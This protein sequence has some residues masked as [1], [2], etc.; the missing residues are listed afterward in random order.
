MRQDKD[1]S[2]KW[3]I[4]RY[5]DS[6]LHLVGITGFARW[7]HLPG[8]VVAPRRLLDGLIELHYP[9]GTDSLVLLEIESYADADADRQVLEDVAVVLL[10]RRRMPE[11]VSLVLKPKGNVRVSGTSERASPSGRTRLVGT[12]PVVQLWDIDAERLLADPDLGL[13]PWVPLARSDQPP[14]QLLARCVERIQTVPDDTRRA[15]LLAVTE[16]LAGL[17][18]PDRRFPALFRGPTTVIESP[19][20]DEAFAFVEARTNRKNIVF[21][22]EDRFGQVPEAVTSGLQAVTLPAAFGELF[23]AALHCPSMNEFE[24]QLRRTYSAR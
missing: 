1:R 22:L 7:T 10:E 21:V 15:A 5:A 3:L 16:I 14:D 18:F 12:W 9:D 24:Q 13:V 20:L 17:A 4:A 23:R 8:E 11:V 2:S 6:I 19:V